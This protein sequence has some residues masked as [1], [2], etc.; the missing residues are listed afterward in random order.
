MSADLMR[1]VGFTEFGGP[2]VL[3]LVS[4]PVPVPGPGEVRVRVA[5]AAV[6]PTDLAFRSG[7]HRS[8]PAGVSPPYVP[9]MDLAGVVDIPGGDSPWAPGDRVMAAVSPWVPGGGAQAEFVVVA[10]D[11]LTRV[12]ESF[13]LQAAATLPMNALTVRAAL[14]ELAPEPGQTL[15]VTGAAG[16]VGGYAIQLGRAEGLRVI[17]DASPADEELVSELGADVVVPRGP[18]VAERM[19]QVFPPGV[20]ALLDAAVMGPQVLAAVRDG[21]QV[22]AVRPFSGESERGITVSLV[23]VFH[24]LHEGDTLARLAEL[25]AKGMLSLRVAD[26]LPA[27]RAAEAHRRFEAHGV[28]GRLVLTFLPAPWNAV[29]MS[30]RRHQVVVVG[31]G[32]GGI[33]VAQALARSDVDV[34]I[35]DRTNHHLFQPL[36]YQV[37]AGILPDGVIAPALRG[38]V[39]KQANAHVVLAEV[40]DLDLEGR[41]VRA[42]APDGRK[43]TLPYDTLVVA[44]GCTD[45]YFGHD[46]W[47]SFAPGLK[48]LRD[49]SR[50]RS[51][52]LGAFEM[53]ELA[54]DPAERAA[55][56]TFAVI[57]A[58]PTGVEMV[59][60]VA[61]LAHESLP[62]EFKSVTTTE[63]KILLIEAGPEVLAAFAPKLQRYTRR[64]LQKMGVDVLLNTAAR[65]MDD[66]SVT[67]KGPD[68][69]R[70]IPARTRIW[71]AGVQASP[72]AA[73]LALATG[74]GT[75]RAGRVA[76]QPDCSLPGH[77]EVFA[78]GDMVLLNDLPG[79]A[80]PAIQE[81]T[82]VGR[83]IRDRLAGKTATAAFAYRDKGSMATIGHLS[84]VTDA[85]GIKFTGVIGYT[86]WGFVHVMYLVGWGN[87]AGAVFNW[88]RAL[89]FTK[90]RAHRTITFERARYELAHHADHDAGEA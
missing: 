33:R 58:G 43:L 23:L 7:A 6:N 81:G 8:M 17:A 79:V 53:A 60:Q 62:R 87:R 52:I 29:L 80:Q 25:A 3:H 21:G 28:R 11:A 84:A 24:H 40:H 42:L 49:A 32:F 5:A 19:R 63:A 39:R 2:E 83:L 26:V 9:G 54:T 50:L 65:A 35:A 72:L 20:D 61:E 31:G 77:P 89:T 38:V 85:F 41:V 73:M 46:E 14:D 78:I 47:S 51:H 36:L 57:G 64:R 86:M 71:A 70:R 30:E 90:N 1:A 13:S 18:G 74:A 22:I 55:Y 69:E 88:A 59:G 27:G 45:A 12:P 67:V 56:L 34:T 44:A 16:A 4:L 48:T 10:A 68:G 15:G 75:D 37:A 82:Y 76:V 66:D